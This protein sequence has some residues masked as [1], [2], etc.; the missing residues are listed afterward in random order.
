MD[1]AKD[2]IKDKLLELYKK[3]DKSKGN[4]LAYRVSKCQIDVLEEVL[5]ELRREE[6]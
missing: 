6:Q 4:T 3:R 2:I 1:K 5:E